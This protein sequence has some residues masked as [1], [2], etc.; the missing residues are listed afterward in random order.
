MIKVIS[1]I[2][3]RPEVI[4]TSILH[5][6]LLENENFELKICSTGQHKDIFEDTLSLFGLAIDKQLDGID[7]SLPLMQRVAEH[8]TSLDELMRSSSP[9][10]CLIQGDTLSGYSAAQAAFMNKVPVVHIEAG[11]RS[12]NMNDPYPEEMFR[13]FIDSISDTL[14][15]PTYLSKQNLVRE[16]IDQDKIFVTGNTTIDALLFALENTN[17]IDYDPSNDLARKIKQVR[18]LGKSPSLLTLHRRENW[19]EKIQLTLLELDQIAQEQN[20]H[21]FYPVHPN[22]SIQSWIRNTE[23]HHVDIL[24]PLPYFDLIWLL[25][26]IDIVFSDSGG[27]QEECAYLKKAIIVLR[28]NTERQEGISHGSAVLWNDFNADQISQYIQSA[29]LAPHHIYGDGTASRQI[30][31]ILQNKYSRASS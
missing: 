6:L 10:I 12:H 13:H 19:G 21:F 20:L 25:Q 1:V 16:H 11:L 7:S 31:E 27:L 15:C 8:T 23:L 4:K 9:D 2:G 14:L 3:T 30:V 18:A 29:A 5:K 26:N 28:E 22:P 17:H 24:T